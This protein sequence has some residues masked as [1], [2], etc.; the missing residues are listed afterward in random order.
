MNN[1][2]SDAMGGVL[3]VD[4]EA[5]IRDLYSEVLRRHHYT[6]VVAQNTEEAR[7]VLK[8]N[9]ID[10]VVCDQ[11]MEGEDGV[12]FLSDLR[13]QYP[14]LQRILVTGFSSEDL[15]LKGINEAHLLYYL[16]KPCLPSDLLSTVKTAFIVCAQE[17]EKMQND[18]VQHVCRRWASGLQALGHSGSVAAL[19]L[20]IIS[21]LSLFAVSL[22]GVVLFAILYL[23]KWM[24][25]ID[26]IPSLHIENILS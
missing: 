17:K 8:A 21:I 14:A 6:V 18:A 1:S 25:G 11:V 5:A 7:H 10:V 23:L 4:D 20:A 15:V 16:K 19:K 26:L 3:V 9:A 12:S 24:L 22:T 13:E 2:Q